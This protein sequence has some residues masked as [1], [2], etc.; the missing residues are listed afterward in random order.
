[1]KEGEGREG[2]GERQRDTML[3]YLHTY[4]ANID[5]CSHTTILGKGMEKAKQSNEHRF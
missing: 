3:I 4:V 5:A 1:M 2:N